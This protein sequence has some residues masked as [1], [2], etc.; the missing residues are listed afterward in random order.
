MEIPFQDTAQNQGMQ[1]NKQQA[2]AK[3]ANQRANA[4]GADP[5]P[6]GTAG[7]IRTSQLQQ[8]ASSFHKG[9]V[10]GRSSEYRK[11]YLSRKQKKS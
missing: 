11:V 10:V 3:K 8:F 7:A 6:A 5:D 2:D 9:G 4:S 1:Q